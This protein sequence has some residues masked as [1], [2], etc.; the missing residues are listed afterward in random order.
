M[1]PQ[2]IALEFLFALSSSQGAAKHFPYPPIRCRIRLVGENG[3]GQFQSQLILTP[4]V[5]LALAQYTDWDG[6]KPEAAC[7]LIWTSRSKLDSGTIRARGRESRRNHGI[8]L[9]TSPTNRLHSNPATTNPSI[10]TRRLEQNAEFPALQKEHIGSL[11]SA[12]NTEMTSLIRARMFWCCHAGFDAGRRRHI[13]SLLRIA[14]KEDLPTRPCFRYSPTVCD[15][16]CGQVQR[17]NSSCFASSRH[18]LHSD[19]AGAPRFERE[20]PTLRQ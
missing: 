12:T 6:N 20:L 11:Y 3:F 15:T 5:A 18:F 13:G 14:P 16:A 8:S 10:K 1:H 4:P 17:K 9:P 19:S 7:T 2:D